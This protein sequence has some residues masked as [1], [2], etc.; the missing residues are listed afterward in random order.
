MSAPVPQEEFDFI[1]S[2]AG[3]AGCVVAARLSESGKYRV[4]LLEAGPEDK[5]F[6][7]GVP[8]GL[9]MLFADPRVNWMFETEP[10]SELNG[11]RM[12]QPRGKVLGGTSSIN[13]MVYIRG[14][15]QD[16]DLWRR[17]GC[18]GWSYED[19]LP[20]FK[21]AEDQQRGAD[22]YH[23][24]GGPLTVSDRFGRCELTEAMVEAAQQAGIPYTPDFNGEQQ[25][26]VGYYQ[27]TTHRNRRVSSAYAYLRPA[28]DRR[29][30]KTLTGALATRLLFEGGRVA[31]IEYRTRAGLATARARCEVVLSGGAFGS[32]HLLQLS[33]LGPA[34]HLSALG[35]AVKADLPQV[36]ANLADHFQASLMFRC[37]KAI[38]INDVANSWFRRV[39]AGAQ[40]VLFKRGAL[41]T[42]GIHAGIF[43]R[44]DAAIARPNVQINTSIWSIGGMSERGLQPHPFPGFT[45]VP[46]HLNP[47]A[48]GTVRLKSADPIAAPEIRQ[49]FLK[50]RVD[51]ETMIAAVRIVR[52]IARQPAMAPYVAA[53]L[54]PSVDARSDA[55]IETYLRSSGIANLHPVGSCRMGAD[56][57]S[58]V[59]PRLRVRGVGGLRIA[60]ASIMP[61]LPA[62][63]TNAPSIMIGEKASAMILED[64]R[65]G[66]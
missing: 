65:L 49:N 9:P 26:G 52:N 13:G 37:T 30:L 19:V 10:E 6:W 42:N 55:E 40:S 16:Y 46:V 38:T 23:G 64:A 20:Y 12:Y 63:N 44:T 5:A 54:S 59:D 62:G 32:P 60:D 43:T 34:A 28:R 4:L 25:E 48:S 29:N 11:R 7:I 35:I 47:V 17:K 41:A 53:E 3:S 45:M 36:G 57:A 2:G 22:R 14:H 31:G 33:G 58:V 8:M 51:V 27:T 18:I 24:V 1:V 66:S 21:K 61:T 15:A 39:A 56:D 50:D